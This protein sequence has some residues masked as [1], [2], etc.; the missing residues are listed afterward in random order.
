MRIVGSITLSRTSEKVAVLSASEGEAIDK[1]ANNAAVSRYLVIAEAD[2][3]CAPNPAR[4]LPSLHL[5][6]R[7]RMPVGPCG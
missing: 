2:L 3:P 1:Q 4:P 5:R 7:R 6:T